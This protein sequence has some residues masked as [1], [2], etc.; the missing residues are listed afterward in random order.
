MK[1][2]FGPVEHVEK[3]AKDADCFICLAEGN[4]HP[5]HTKRFEKEWAKKRLHKFEIND[6]NIDHRYKDVTIEDIGNIASTLVG[7]QVIDETLK[8]KSWVHINCLAGFSRS[9]AI[10]LLALLINQEEKPTLKDFQK[11]Y[12]EISNGVYRLP[13]GYTEPNAEICKLIRQHFNLEVI[14]G[15]FSNPT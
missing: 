10:T 13:T 5:C 7:I 9:A 1:I 8:E 2:T 11:Y 14:D 15:E 12:A 3:Y 4:N 6:K